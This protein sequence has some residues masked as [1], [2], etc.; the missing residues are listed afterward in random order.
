MK[1]REKY[2]IKYYNTYEDRNH[3]NETPGGD[4]PGK[5]TIHIGEDHGMA[6]LTEEDVKFCRQKYKEGLRSRDIHTK[7]FKDK[8][9]YSGFLR[10]WHG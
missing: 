9:N 4:L 6:K 5:N 8:I 2:W 1:E 3:Y 10:M 7:Y